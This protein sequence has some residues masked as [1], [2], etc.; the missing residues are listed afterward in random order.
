[1]KIKFTFE[2]SS[3]IDAAEVEELLKTSKV[4]Y[5]VDIEGKPAK[6]SSRVGRRTRIT[7]IELAAVVLSIKQNPDWGDTEVAK[8]TNVSSATV[9]RIRAGSHALQQH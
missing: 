7:K 4:K 6:K 9:M 8:S 5:K 2:V 3:F 1:M